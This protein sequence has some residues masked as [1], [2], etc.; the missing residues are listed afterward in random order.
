MR[1][2]S[3]DQQP[4][5]IREAIG[6][7]RAQGCTIDQIRAVLDEEHG[8]ELSRSALGRHVQK[9]DRLR[10]R[11]QESR[12]ISEALV[13]RLEDAGENR[14]LRLLVELL[15][16]GMFD[17]LSQDGSDGM[18]PRDQMFLASAVQKLAQT[19]R[20]DA[21]YL[22]RVRKAAAEKAA[23]EARAAAADA[24][25]TA[26]KKEGLSA[27]ALQRIRQDIYGIAP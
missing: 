6:T 21:D 1:P 7:L 20:T 3:I 16:A 14:Q 25:E 18:D 26:A 9:L 11:L 4:E 17:A 22:E 19:L 10:V 13:A 23:A 12:Q 2:S 24:A 27:E 8:V 5:A 15:G